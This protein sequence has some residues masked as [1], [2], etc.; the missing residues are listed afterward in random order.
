FG[1]SGGLRA[2]PRSPLWISTLQGAFTDG[3]LSAT[4]VSAAG[5][6]IS[7]VVHLVRHGTKQQ[8]IALLLELISVVIWFQLFGSVISRAILSQPYDTPFWA[9][10]FLI[11]GL[12]GTL[13]ASLL[14]AGLGFWI[15]APFIW[16]HPER[17]YGFWSFFCLMMGGLSGMTFLA[18]LARLS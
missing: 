3:L 10:F 2:G 6:L 18:C 8:R 5:A 7:S 9:G 17:E 12:M 4:L 16:R 11:G 15:G 14:G 13:I 1:G